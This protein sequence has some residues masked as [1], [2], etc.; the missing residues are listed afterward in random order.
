VKVKGR[1]IFRKQL[2]KW[3]IIKDNQVGPSP[4]YGQTSGTKVIDGETLVQVGR[5]KG[6]IQ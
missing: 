6:K 2:L 4:E 1:N 5:S 3:N